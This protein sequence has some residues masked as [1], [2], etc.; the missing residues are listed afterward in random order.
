MSEEKENKE[1]EELDI[2]IEGRGYVEQTIKYNNHQYRFQL[3]VGS[4]IED[5]VIPLN[6]FQEYVNANIAEIKKA[7]QGD[8]DD[9]LRDE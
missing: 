4:Q 6:Q 3:P 2:K 5:A 9:K 1:Q 8:E 7:S